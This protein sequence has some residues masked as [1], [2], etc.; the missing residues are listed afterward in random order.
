MSVRAFRPLKAA[1]GARSGHAY[2]AAD[3]KRQLDNLTKKNVC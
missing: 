3:L 2:N 1:I